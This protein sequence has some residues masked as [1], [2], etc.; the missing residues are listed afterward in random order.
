M[1]TAR[2]QDGSV[3]SRIAQ[4]LRGLRA[5]R[6]WSLDALAQ[7]S[8]VSR[9]TLSRLENAEVSATASVLGKLCAAYGLPMSRLMHMVEDGFAPLVRRGAQPVWTDAT[10]GFR[11]RSVSPPAQP[12]AG[13]VLA[14]E[15]GAGARITYDRPPR[16]G[17][18]HHLVLIKGRLQIEVNGQT[19]D[20]K[21]GDCLR[22]QLFGPSAFAT[23]KRCGA[24]YYLFIV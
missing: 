6:R 22:Y 3:D 1:E 8:G 23:P 7:R 19:H 14:C 11:R 5:E 2:S 20:L 16:E 10:L 13:E 24:R 17:L 4:R 12:L 18:E 21:P 15:L 9:A